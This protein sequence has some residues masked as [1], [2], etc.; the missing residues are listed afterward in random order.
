MDYQKHYNLLIYKAINNPH[1]GYTEKHHIV[2]QCMG[3]N[4][5]KSNIVRLSAKQHFV[6][7]HLLFKIYGGSKLANAW[8]AMCRI[9]K[10]QESRIVNASMFKKAKEA[11]SKQLSVESKG[12]LNHFYGKT[13]SI[14][15]RAKMSAAQKKIKL[16]ENRSEEHKNALLLSQKKSKTPEHKAKIGRK[17][18]IMLQN[19]VSGEIIRI[20]KTDPRAHSK[21]WVHPRKLKPETKH[22]CI[23][24]G[25]ITTCGNLKRW[26]NDNCKHKDTY[27]N[28]IN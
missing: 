9:G 14:E 15:S 2:P 12:E 6:A 1:K 21:K 10:G 11:R 7:H 5:S 18:M 26:H 8:Y 16:W 24:C 23:H 17:G 22:A 4:N 27:E 28:Q 3:G 20:D 19:V 25:I 13:H